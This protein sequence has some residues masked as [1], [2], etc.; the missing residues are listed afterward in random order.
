V[1]THAAE[2]EDVP[3]HSSGHATSLVLFDDDTVLGQLLLHQQHSLDSLNHEIATLSPAHK[4]RERHEHRVNNTTNC[5]VK[6]CVRA[7]VRERKLTGIERTLL[8]CGELL[9]VLIGEDALAGL[10]HDRHATDDDAVTDHDLLAARVLDI[11][12]DGR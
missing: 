8:E 6:K 5:R 7:C 2:K 10:E 9:L 1:G 12:R 11:D 4:R 3:H